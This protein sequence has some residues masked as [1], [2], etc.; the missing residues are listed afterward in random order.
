MQLT[1]KDSDES[2]IEILWDSGGTVD[3]N[4]FKP[5]VKV[6]DV[7]TP[8]PEPV[9]ACWGFDVAEVK[10]LQHDDPDLAFLRKWL[11]TEDSPNEADLFIASPAAK[12]YWLSK[13]EFHI[14]GNLLY[15]QP[16]DGL[17]A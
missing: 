8:S 9:L 17:K 14:I 2:F 1:T 13:E 11:E 6:C 7:G 10:K 15:H 5:V 4:V 12:S 3:V 16:P